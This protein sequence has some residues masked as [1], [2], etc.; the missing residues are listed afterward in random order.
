[1]IENNAAEEKEHAHIDDQCCE[2]K[3][4]AKNFQQ[5]LQCSQSGQPSVEILQKENEDRNQVERASGD[6][7]E[8]EKLELQLIK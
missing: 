8:Q 3:I 4:R 5:E 7:G 6:A 2:E 1:V